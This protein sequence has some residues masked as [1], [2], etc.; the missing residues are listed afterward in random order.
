[1]TPDKRRRIMD[2]VDVWASFYR[3]NPQRFAEDY[4]NLHLRLFQKILLFMMNI[5]DFFCYIAARG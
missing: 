2:G 1:M 5:S 3:A 4:L